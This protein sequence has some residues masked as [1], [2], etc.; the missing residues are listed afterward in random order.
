MCGESLSGIILVKARRFFRSLL[1]EPVVESRYYGVTGPFSDQGGKLMFRAPRVCAVLALAFAALWMVAG[2]PSGPM[3]LGTA[4]VTGTALLNGRPIPGQTIL[5]AGDSIETRAG[6]RV[7]VNLPGRDRIILAENSGL[8]LRGAPDAVAAELKHGR[9]LVN[10][11]GR[12]REVRLGGEGVSIAAGAASEFL[13]TRL[14]QVSYVWAKAGRLAI[15]DEGYGTT[16]EVPAGMVGVVRPDAAWAPPQ[17]QAQPASRTGSGQ[18]A[19]EIR[20]V[21]PADY[22][23][24]GSQKLQGKP[25]DPINWQDLVQTETRGR[26]RMVLD[27]GSIL[28][29]GSGSQLRVVQHDAKSQV[30]DL[31]LNY[32]RMRAQVVKL[33][34]STSRFDVR[35]NTAICGVLGTDFYLEADAKQTKLIVFEGRVDFRPLAAVGIAAAAAAVTV[36]AG[37]SS[38]AAAGAVTAPVAAGTQ[39]VNAASATTNVAGGQA[40]GAGGAVGAQAASRVAVIAATAAPPAAVA[41]T[42]LGVSNQTPTG[43]PPQVSVRQP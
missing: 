21:I 18:R 41:G 32:G 14:P 27:D 2:S 9:L 34:Q 1:G 23:I 12:V 33:A 4:L 15:T 36:L 16:T 20:L 39:A 19:G 43:T 25:G 7:T 37:Q 31:T 3:V 11:S 38:T 13:V 6:G 17:A 40:A 24:R 26:V 28:S 10:S 8:A 5:T 42:A 30:T 22:V 35:T 29:L